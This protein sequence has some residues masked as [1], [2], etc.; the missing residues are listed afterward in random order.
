MSSTEGRMVVFA[1]LEKTKVLGIEIVTDKS[2]K[3]HTYT[4]KNLNSI[5]AFTMAFFVIAS[6]QLVRIISEVMANVVLIIVTAVAF[7]LAVGVYHTG[8]DE[9]NIGKGWKSLFFVISFIA[10]LLIV[11]NALG[12]L[13]GIYQFLIRNWNNTAVVSIFTLLIFVAL[14]MWVTGSFS[15]IGKSNKGDTKE[16]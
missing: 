8:Q 1:F 10:V 16:D 12:W 15:R 2:G 6:S 9:M 11:F 3:D 13:Q 14:M 7:M 5:V 4:R